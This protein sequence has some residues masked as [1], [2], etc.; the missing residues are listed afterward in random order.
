MATA[1]MS[2]ATAERPMVTAGRP[3]VTTTLATGSTNQVETGHRRRGIASTAKSNRGSGVAGAGEAAAAGPAREPRPENGGRQTAGSQRLTW[4]TTSRSRP[5][6]E[7]G[8]QTTRIRRLILPNGQLH[9]QTN[10]LKKAGPGGGDVAPAR[11]ARV[12]PRPGNHSLAAAHRRAADNQTAHGERA[13]PDPLGTAAAR[14][15]SRLCPDGTTKTTR[16]SNFLVSRRLPARAKVGPVAA[17]R[18]TCSRKAA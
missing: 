3:A 16:G 15:T 13:N 7:A 12:L 18:M 14:P 4:P 9:A 17:T 1:E 5:V 11:M 8:R 2:V 6:T 10:R